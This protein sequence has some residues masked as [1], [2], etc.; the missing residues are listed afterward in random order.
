M[1]QSCPSLSAADALALEAYGDLFGGTLRTLH[2]RRA[3]KKRDD[4][5][6][7]MRRLARWDVR[8]DSGAAARTRRRRC[9]PAEVD[10][11]ALGECAG[12]GEAASSR[13]ARI[14]AD[15]A[16]CTTASAI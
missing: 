4:K 16:A 5:P 3:A 12:S 13:A 11:E 6:G 14:P 9:T 2:A 7:T 1:F 10:D 15:D 8:L